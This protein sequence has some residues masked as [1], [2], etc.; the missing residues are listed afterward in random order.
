MA[1]KDG[2]PMPGEDE[3]LHAFV[4][5][6]TTDSV[7]KAVK[8]INDIIK[9]GIELPENQ[10]DL[11]RSQLR[12]LAL[13]NGTLRENEGP[14]CTNCGANNHRSW[15]CPDKLNV[16][17]NVYCTNCNGAGHIAKD[18]KEERVERSSGGNQA[19]IDQE[20]LSLMA[21]LGEEG[22][23]TGLGVPSSF[24]GSGRSGARF[25]GALMG[26]VE[27]EPELNSIKI[28]PI[29]STIP[30]TV[31][32]KS[33]RHPPLTSLPAMGPPPPADAN[34]VTPPVPVPSAYGYSAAAGHDAYAAYGGGWPSASGTVG[35]AAG[36]TAAGAAAA[37]TTPAAAVDPAAAAA[38]AAY[39][40][41]YYM[42]WYA[43]QAYAAQM[44]ASTDPQA[45]ASTAAAS[46][47]QAVPP[48]PPPPLVGGD[49]SGYYS[50]QPPPPPP[51]PSH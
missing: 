29:T 5:G 37:A 2:Q 39:Y 40:D 4:T 35:V 48:P 51:P 28:A 47:G 20:Y 42:Q 22:G 6:P 19:K 1:R 15:Q 14:R 41:P 49:V 38:A 17:N 24:N 32:S 8:C 13:L 33:N 21:E 25:G 11:R 34:G 36:T 10:N 23:S 16:T 26:G 27:P 30:E 44:A 9:K 3:P 45:A 18:C 50:A 12:E 46:A 7:V 31:S 43:A